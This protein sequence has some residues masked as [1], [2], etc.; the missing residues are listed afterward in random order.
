LELAAPAELRRKISP[1]LL[2]FTG[3]NGRAFRNLQIGLAIFS[4]YGPIT[5]NTDHN[6][7]LYLLGP[8]VCSGVAA[9]IW[10]SL[11]HRPYRG[12][13]YQKTQHDIGTDDPA[14]MRLV[15]LYK[16]DELRHHLG[17]ATLKVAGA[18]FATLGIAAF[19]VRNSLNW[20]L[21]SPENHFHGSAGDGFWARLVMAI[22]FA[23]LALWGDCTGWCITTWARR[24]IAS[25]G[26]VSIHE[27][28]TAP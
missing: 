5:A 6:A 21:P 13:F 3:G 16:S 15:E 22:L 11:P 9:L 12:L 19:L 23:L 25:H 24:E 8:W 26:N 27:R 20:A 28:M 17:N 14:V 1:G 10:S 4:L 18:L 2:M 7:F